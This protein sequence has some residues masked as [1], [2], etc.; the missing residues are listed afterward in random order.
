MLV[1][2]REWIADVW[3]AHRDDLIGVG[4]AALLCL[5]VVVAL[6]VLVP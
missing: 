1:L 5:G 3:Q 4:Q 2:M 6:L